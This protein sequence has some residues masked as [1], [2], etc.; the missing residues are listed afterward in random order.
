MLRKALNK[1]VSGIV[2]VVC[3]LLLGLVGGVSAKYI[4]DAGVEKK[5]L[6]AKEF[7]FT[8][9]LLAE[10]GTNYVLNADVTSVAFNLG[11]N[12]DK[13]RFSED[14][15]EYTVNVTTVNLEGAEE[16][17]NWTLKT[18][19]PE[20]ATPKLAG[21][22]KSIHTL[23]LSG[24][25]KDKKYIV[26]ATGTSVYTDPV[27]NERREGYVKTLTATFE[28]ADDGVVLHKYLDKHTDSAYVLLTVWAENLAGHLNVK[29]P[30]VDEAGKT[31][32]IP[33]NTDLIMKNID[34]YDAGEYGTIEFADKSSFEEKYSSYTYR[35]FIDEKGSFSEEDFCVCMLYE[36][37]GVTMK[38]EATKKEPK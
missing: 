31:A 13:L 10:E 5:V 34:N 25:E 16:K 3:L 12:A 7:Y 28:L 30:R 38:H 11:N 29:Y 36:E 32:L 20:S 26:T 27:T 18:V 19:Q 21:G 2:I 22:E 23:E 24:I 4:H 35:F 1:K 14:D 6:R 17:G 9:D 33:D 15:V 8:S 37:D